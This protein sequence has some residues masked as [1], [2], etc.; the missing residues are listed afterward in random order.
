MGYKRLNV[1]I[2][3][4]LLN[5]VDKLIKAGLYKNRCDI[6]NYALRQIE[7]LKM[8]E[9][10]RTSKLLKETIEKVESILEKPIHKSLEEKKS[11]KLG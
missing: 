8:L 2:E 6:I 4:N 1:A 5:D 11:G 9:T 10:Q 7:P 3:E